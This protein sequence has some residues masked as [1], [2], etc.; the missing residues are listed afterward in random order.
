METRSSLRDPH[1]TMPRRMRSFAPAMRAYERALIPAATIATPDCLT[2]VLR[3]IASSSLSAQIVTAA[4]QTFWLSPHLLQLACR[5]T[6]EI[7]SAIGV[8]TQ[9][10]CR[11]SCRDGFREAA[12]NDVRLARSGNG[13]NEP[14]HAKKRGNCQSDGPPRNVFNARKPA[15]GELLLLAGV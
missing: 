11:T 4:K 12:I 8:R 2:N 10:G 14:G 3:S 6:I 1:P 7:D 13:G 9:D 15:L 5:F